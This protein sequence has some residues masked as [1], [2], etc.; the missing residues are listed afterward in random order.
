MNEVDIK[1]LIKELN[2]RLREIK[3]YQELNILKKEVEDNNFVFASKR[4]RKCIYDITLIEGDENK[5]SY[6][7]N[8]GISSG[9]AYIKNLYKYFKIKE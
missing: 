9:E 8:D 6:L 5:V 2:I 3:T 1:E 7:Y 4:S